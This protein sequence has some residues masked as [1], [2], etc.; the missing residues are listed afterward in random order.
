MTVSNKIGD[1]EELY[2]KQE[3]IGKGSF[4]EV[5]KGI[6]KKTNETIAIKIIDL[7]DA[8]DEIEDIQQEINVLSQC[9]SPFVTK[10]QASY[11][12]GTKLWIIMEYLAGGSVLDLMKP[13]P[14]DESYIAIVLRELLKGLEYLHSEGKIHRDIK[15]ANVLLSANGDVKLAD[16]GVSGQLTD[17]MTKRNT[18]VGTPFWMAPEV[19]KQTGYDS[20]ADI[21][22]MGITALEMAKGEPP[23]A[24]LHPMRALFLI[25]KD[26]APTLEGN[27]SKA[28]KEFCSLCLNKDPNLRPTAK[29]LLKNR[30]IKTAKKTSCL[31]ELIERRQKWIHLNGASAD[32]EEETDERQR[33]IINDD[34]GWDFPTIKGPK[35]TTPVMPAAKPAA[36]ATNVNG[37]VDES[38]SRSNPTTPSAPSPSVTSNGRPAPTNNTPVAAAPVVASTTTPAPVLATSS[39]TPAGNGAS[40]DRQ[41]TANG[42]QHQP[43]ASA[44]TSVIYPVLSKLLKSTQDENVV[45][46]L[47][48]LKMAFDNAEKTKPGITHMMIAQVIETLKR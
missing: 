2:T 33:T 22:S 48:Q 37:K 35:T 15:A 28:F 1:P 18:F 46:A 27:F 12:K 4:G 14:L 29:D 8:E 43:R 17:Q 19:I 44:L 25:P 41:V 5:F 21:W 32:D 39:P 30:F 23:R 10:Y 34:G 16:F 13:G 3:R 20:K 38:R 36:S 11:L 6:N 7:E 31:T 40:S 9:E 47:A 45:N 42:A 26:P 24:D